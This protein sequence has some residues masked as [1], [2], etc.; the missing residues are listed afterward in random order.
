MAG[1]NFNRKCTNSS[2][3]ACVVKIWQKNAKSAVMLLTLIVNAHKI[4]IDR[5]SKIAYFENSRDTSAPGLFGTKT[6]RH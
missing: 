5:N 4:S 1:Q 3:Y 2:F 6:L